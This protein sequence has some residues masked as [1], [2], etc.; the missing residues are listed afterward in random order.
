MRKEQPLILQFINKSTGAIH[1][2]GTD[3]SL[4]WDLTQRVAWLGRASLGERT[5][6]TDAEFEEFRDLKKAITHLTHALIDQVPYL[7]ADLAL[8]NSWAEKP[9]LVP[10]LGTHGLVQHC[11]SFPAALAWIAVQAVYFLGEAKHGQIR[12]C[13]GCSIVFFD[14]SPT[15]RR[16]WCL[17]TRCG[18]YSKVRAFNERNK[19]GMLT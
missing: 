6:A 16:K 4:H 3:A 17:M 15:A 13:Q 5:F 18:N 10:E 8:L 2:G 1:V 11:Q 14:S 12:K 19:S 7:E 9:S